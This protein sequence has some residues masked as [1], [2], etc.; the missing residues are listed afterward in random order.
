[1][2]SAQFLVA[3]AL[4]RSVSSIEPSETSEAYS[5]FSK[6]LAAPSA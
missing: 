3:S 2:L 4:C 1:M 6:A 5:I